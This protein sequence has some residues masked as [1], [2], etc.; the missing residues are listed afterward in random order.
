MNDVRENFTASGHR[1]AFRPHPQGH[2]PFL[3]RPGTRG[4]TLGLMNKSRRCL[5]RRGGIAALAHTPKASTPATNAAV[6]G[7]RDSQLLSRTTGFA[8][9]QSQ[10]MTIP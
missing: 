6:Q 3:A 10:S 4:I 8:S 9:S 5:S 7:L 2:G 1:F